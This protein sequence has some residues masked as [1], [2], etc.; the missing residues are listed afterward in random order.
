MLEQRFVVGVLEQVLVG[1]HGRGS[2][3]G[4]LRDGADRD[5]QPFRSIAA[6]FGH[7]SAQQPVSGG[8]PRESSQG[9]VEVEP[10]EWFGLGCVGVADPELHAVLAGDGERETRA[11][12][13][14]CGEPHGRII[15][16]SN[17]TILA[18][19]QRPECEAD[20]AARSVA[21]V[22]G[23]I[24]AHAREP[25]HGLG[26]LAQRRQI[27]PLHEKNVR[28]VGREAD[29]GRGWS[30][31]NRDDLRRREPVRLLGKRLAAQAADQ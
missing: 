6:V 29:R 16:Q 26:Q 9:C 15:G 1:A 14:P 17:D 7:E 4:L 20:V 25:G 11:V 3:S 2:L 8:H 18:V 30:V 22:G 5:A 28:T 21:P 31:E 10:G 23:G 13:R 12:W 24:E 19:G 27:L